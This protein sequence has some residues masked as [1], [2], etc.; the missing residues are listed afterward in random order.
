MKWRSGN[1]SPASPPA[2]STVTVSAPFAPGL[3][4]W[5]E[6]VI[7]A[8]ACETLAGTAPVGEEYASTTTRL[9]GTSSSAAQTRRRAVGHTWGV[10][11]GDTGWWG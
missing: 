6:A 8:G 11:R 10:N 7:V 4:G 5:N 1:V 3:S 2:G 9:E